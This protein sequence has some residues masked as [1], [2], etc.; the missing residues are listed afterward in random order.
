MKKDDHRIEELEKWH[1]E[2]QIDDGIKKGL[3]RWAHTI[4][5]TATSALMTA[6]YTVGSFVADKWEPLQV[7]IKAFIAANKGSH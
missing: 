4:C 6:V 3:S 5:M 2:K 1:V 7:A